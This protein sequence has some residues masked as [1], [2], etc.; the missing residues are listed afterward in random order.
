MLTNLSVQSHPTSY[1]VWITL[2]EGE[3][4]TDL[5]QRVLRRGVDSVPGEEYAVAAREGD[6]SLRISLGGEPKLSRLE[7][8]IQILLE[9][10]HRPR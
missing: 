10:L 5:T 6:G 9:E 1:H 2:P 4:A 7:E 8:G 3:S